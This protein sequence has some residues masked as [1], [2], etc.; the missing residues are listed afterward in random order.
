MVGYS[1]TQYTTQT[2]SPCTPL[3]NNTS[4]PGKRSRKA[5]WARQASRKLS[6][7]CSGGAGRGC[8]EPRGESLAVGDEVRRQLWLAGPLVVGSLMQNLIQTISVM[9]VGHLGE[10]PLA[11]ASMATSFATVT[12]ISLLVISNI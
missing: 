7:R 11:G 2:H 9:F 5:A 10:L 12:G 3:I 1:T 6:D 4:G 8:K